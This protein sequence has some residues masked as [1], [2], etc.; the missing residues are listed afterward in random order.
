MIHSKAVSII[1]KN[2]RKQLGQLGCTHEIEII[3]QRIVEVASLRRK[4]WNMIHDCGG[5]PSRDT[6]LEVQRNLVH[7]HGQLVEQ[8]G[9]EHQQSLEKLIEVREGEVLMDE[10]FVF[11]STTKVIEQVKAKLQECT[12]SALESMW[13]AI[14]QQGNK[15]VIW[16]TLEKDLLSALQKSYVWLREVETSGVVLPEF[17]EDEAYEGVG[18]PCGL[19][20]C[21]MDFLNVFLEIGQDLS[22]TQSD[23]DHRHALHNIDAMINYLYIVSEKCS[24]NMQESHHDEKEE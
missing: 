23:D 22:V 15:R 1:A 12:D 7:C 17:I 4:I 14:A 13:N 5:M 24:L 18:E 11:L 16:E 10:Y 3:Q 21:V 6:I 19:P 9:I 8:V 20:E 2:E